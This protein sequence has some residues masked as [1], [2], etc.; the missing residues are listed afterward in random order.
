MGDSISHHQPHVQL[1]KDHPRVVIPEMGRIMYNLGWATGTGG[2]LSMR[3][4][5]NIYVSPSGILKEKIRGEDLFVLSENG[6][7]R[8]VPHPHK[9]LR[10]SSCTPIFMCIYK[11][12]GVGA[13]IH[14]HS[15]KAVMATILFPGKEFRVSNLQMI[16]GIC[17]CNTWGNHR[18]DD[19]LVVPV[20]ENAYEESDLCDGLIEAIEQYPDTCAVL[21]RR[22]GICVW[23]RTWEEAKSMAENYDYVFNV[24]V[25]MKKC[26]LDP[27]SSDS[28]QRSF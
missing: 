12:S 28:T 13:V 17:K 4:N 26:G 27:V 2:S 18:Y 19:T 3:Y 1:T 14:S 22:H 6:E 8:E 7:E 5:G 10:R 21:I 16:K 24:A 15:P 11:L 9:N 25:E 20:I 23:G